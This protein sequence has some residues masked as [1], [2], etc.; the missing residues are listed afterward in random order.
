MATQ[1]PISTISYNTEAFLKEKLELWYSQHIIQAYQYIWHKGED[2]DK[3]HFHVRVEPNKKLDPMD[4]QAMMLEYQIG[5][6]KPLGCR[7]FRQSKEEDW[8]LYV[9]HDP[10]YL[11]LKYGEEE[12]DGKIEYDWTEI[13]TSEWYDLETAWIRAKASLKH[14]AV[15]MAKRL[16]NGEKPID[17]VLQGENVFT[18]NGI[19]RTLVSTDYQRNAEALKDAQDQVSRLLYAIDKAGLKVEDHEDGSIDLVP[20]KQN[21]VEESEDDWYEQTSL[22]DASGKRSI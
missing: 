19:I 9:V 16:Q 11:A 4:L 2:G 15:N 8:F 1:K 13:K 14:N 17:L 6:E 12:K 20:K 18:V 7:P 22:P 21:G 10:E 3:D 5:K